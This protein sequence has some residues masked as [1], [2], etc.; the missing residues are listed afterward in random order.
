ME[1][2]GHKYKKS[3]T[4]ATKISDMNEFSDFARSRNARVYFM[5]S[6]YPQELFDANKE[7]FTNAY[8]ELQ[9]KLNFGVLGTPDD[10]AY[11]VEFFTDTPNHL[12]LTGK[13]VRTEKIVEL[14]GIE[15]NAT[16]GRP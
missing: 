4:D 8:G 2:Y 7:A 3:I 14:L 15:L 6:V 11:P 1:W 16:S 5:F 10:F 13:K 12:S 9:Q